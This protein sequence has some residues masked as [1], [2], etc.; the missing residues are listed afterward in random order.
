MSE[1]SVA[2]SR[3][4]LDTRCTQTIVC[5]TATLEKFAS[6]ANG[7]VLRMR[8]IHMNEFE[9]YSRILDI[10]YHVH[11]FLNFEVLWE[12]AEAAD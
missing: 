6:V 2:H 11:V 12:D 7:V 4:S 1:T 8:D 9:L 3:P 10:S 5:I